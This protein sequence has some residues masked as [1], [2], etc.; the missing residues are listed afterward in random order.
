VGLPDL[1]V[2]GRCR[3]SLG[4]LLLLCRS[5][6]GSLLLLCRL[7]ALV[8]PEVRD[9]TMSTNW[10]SSLCRRA[11]RSVGAVSCVS[12]MLATKFSSS[13]FR[14]SNN[15][16]KPCTKAPPRYMKLCCASALLVLCRY[17]R[18]TKFSGA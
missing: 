4:S 8:L 9:G 10:S 13:G 5:S 7:R 14:C 12:I 11:L 15:I 16:P 6:L 18:L 1:P 17:A 3:S 2:G